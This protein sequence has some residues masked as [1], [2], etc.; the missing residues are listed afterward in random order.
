M[1]PRNAPVHLGPAG[2][3]SSHSSVSE[4]LE[5]RATST[6]WR[7]TVK[8]EG[9][10]QRHTMDHLGGIASVCVVAS[11]RHSRKRDKVVC[12]LFSIA[13]EALSDAA[14][15]E[16][17]PLRHSCAVRDPDR[18]R[19]QFKPKHSTRSSC[20]H[21][22]PTQQLGYLSV[23]AARPATEALNGLSWFGL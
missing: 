1:E 22:L 23:C 8:V 11:A 5:P 12:Q 18:A 17:Y 2:P 20:L 3:L 21:K 14:T 15:D 7:Q 16:V 4:K 6:D 19:G 13:E 9:S 10:P